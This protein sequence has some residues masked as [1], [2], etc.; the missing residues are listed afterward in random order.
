MLLLV[1]HDRE[2]TLR[3]A[4]DADAALLVALVLEKWTPAPDPLGDPMLLPRGD[5]DDPVRL[6]DFDWSDVRHSFRERSG[7]APQGGARQAAR[8]R[9]AESAL[10]GGR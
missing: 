4:I 2:A 7:R 6:D 8:S 1:T 10:R 5:D 3:A 9:L